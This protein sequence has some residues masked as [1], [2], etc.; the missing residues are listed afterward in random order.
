[1]DRRDVKNNK[2]GFAEIFNI[3]FEEINNPMI[4]PATQIITFFSR[5][6]RYFQSII[7][8]TQIRKPNCDLYSA[9]YDK[10]LLVLEDYKELNRL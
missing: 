3:V 7:L 4:F 2:V 6:I 1:M 5:I 8:Q 10:D 9:Y